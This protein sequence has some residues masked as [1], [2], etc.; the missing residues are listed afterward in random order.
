MSRH[1]RNCRHSTDRRARAIR[2]LDA[3]EVGRDSDD[4]DDAGEGGGGE[5][6]GGGPEDGLFGPRVAAVDD[7]GACGE[8]FMETEG[9]RVGCVGGEDQG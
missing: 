6:D 8:V 2:R 3:P 7:G 4:G 1:L 9:L 5:E